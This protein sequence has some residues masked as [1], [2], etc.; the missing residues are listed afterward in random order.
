MLVVIA[1]FCFAYLH[2]VVA[3]LGLDPPWS[4]QN[5]LVYLAMLGLALAVFGRAA[6]LLWRV[7]RR[8]T[9]TCGQFPTD[10]NTIA[11]TTRAFS[12]LRSMHYE[13]SQCTRDK[14]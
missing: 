13:R 9:A 14:I 4:T 10:A 6:W 8:L 7:R 11:T 2:R 1:V 5:H 3:H 12:K